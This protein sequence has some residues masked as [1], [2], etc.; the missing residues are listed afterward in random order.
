MRLGCGIAMRSQDA[1][2]TT[3]ARHSRYKNTQTK[4]TEP[5]PIPVIVVAHVRSRSGG[6]YFA[7]LPLVHAPM[8][9]LPVLAKQV[10][11]LSLTAMH[12]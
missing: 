11:V 9:L 1:A 7:R 12:A 3:G 5:R 10:L 4:Q 6:G 8:Q 2:A